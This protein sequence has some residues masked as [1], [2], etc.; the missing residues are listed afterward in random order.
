MNIENMTDAEIAAE[1]DRR[2]A[3]ARTAKISELN[4]LER[5]AASLRAELGTATR[6]VT[7][8]SKGRAGSSMTG[9]ATGR[10]AVPASSVAPPSRG[11]ITALNGWS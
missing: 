4:D 8:A 10:I 1:M 5:R 6:T 2:K 9:G 7:R 11:S 3:A